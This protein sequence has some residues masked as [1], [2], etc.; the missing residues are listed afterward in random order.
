MMMISDTLPGSIG[1]YISSVWI[2]NITVDGPPDG[3]EIAA[4]LSQRVQKWADL[5]KL[6]YREVS[7]LKLLDS[8]TLTI[9][10]RIDLTIKTEYATL[11]KSPK[12]MARVLGDNSGNI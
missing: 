8:D 2:S 10:E 9:E 1:K 4:E 6:T 7:D 3:F 11:L 12:L 5:L